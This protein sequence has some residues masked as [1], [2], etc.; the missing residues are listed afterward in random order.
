MSPLAPALWQL[1]PLGSPQPRDRR[2]SGAAAP[3]PAAGPLRSVPGRFAAGPTRQLGLP[4]QH[5]SPRLSHYAHCCCSSLPAHCRAATL[6]QAHEPLPCRAAPQQHGPPAWHQCMPLCRPPCPPSSAA[7]AAASQQV[8]QPRRPPVPPQAQAC[9]LERWRSFS[10]APCL[11]SPAE[12][13]S[14]ATQGL[15]VSAAPAE[16]LAAP[17]AAAA[18]AV[19][20]GVAQAPGCQHRWML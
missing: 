7:A 2:H 1:Q 17:A 6:L 9:T 11:G 8:E 16:H 10:W 15:P 19:D 5:P 13:C 4:S 20:G 14:S 18:T 12:V 3:P